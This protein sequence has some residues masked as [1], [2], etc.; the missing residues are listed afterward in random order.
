VI[1]AT[2]NAVAVLIIACP[3]ALGLA[4]PTAIM[5]GTGR[6]AE[7]GIL[8]RS[9]AA[10]E[11]AGKVTTVIFDK[12]GTL[13]EGRPAVTDVIALAGTTETELVRLTAAA[14]R[15]SEHAL[16][17]AIVKAAQE[18]NLD[19]VDATDFTAIAGS[20]IEA[21]VESRR[22]LIGTR[23]LLE[24][25]GIDLGALIRAGDE[26]TSA[27]K[28][29][30][31]VAVDGRAIG[32]MA[33]ADTL[34]PGAPEAVAALRARGIEVV[35]LTGDNAATA[36]AVAREA[37]IA[38]VLAD[39]RPDDKAA[40]VRELQASERIVAMVG[41]GINDAPALAQADVGIAIGGGADIALEAADVT[42]MRGDPRSVTAAIDLSRATMRTIRQNLFWAFF[43]NVALIPV[44]AGALY[45]VFHDTGVPDGLGFFFG[46]YGFLN[47]MLAGAAMAFSSLSV[48]LNSLRLRSAV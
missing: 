1:Y 34:K 4:T 2:L 21:T 45:L 36:Q 35:L 17:E 30:I 40:K 26:L 32:L 37:G 3:C 15:G 31:Y 10:L 33:I 6:G 42:L 47:P 44:A 29:V 20:G 7:A 13:T 38:V 27:A 16:G 18:R 48:M 41:D 9:G 46:S 12:T 23:R 24:E 11:T 19:L 8:I 22:L 14:E 5:V 43:Y 25:R 39:V 28:T